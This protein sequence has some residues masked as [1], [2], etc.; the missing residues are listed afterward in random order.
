M[1]KSISETLADTVLADGKK[2]FK[3]ICEN[4]PL[5]TGVVSQSEFLREILEA[6]YMR[7]FGDGVMTGGAYD[8]LAEHSYKEGN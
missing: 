7:G 6:I 2:R 8:R 3:N 5:L 4:D 1:A